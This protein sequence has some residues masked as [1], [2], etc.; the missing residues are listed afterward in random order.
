MLLVSFVLVTPQ[1]VTAAGKMVIKPILKAGWRYDSNYFKSET[2]DHAVSTYS[3]KPGILVGYETAKSIIS[4]D[5]SL[6]FQKYHDEDD[7]PAGL[8]GADEDDYTGQLAVFKAESQL[9]DRLSI[10]L[11]ETYM[12]T[13]DPASSE[14]YSN[15]TER[16]SGFTPHIQTTSLTT[17]IPGWKIPRRIVG[18]LICF[19]ISIEEPLLIWIIRF[20]PGIMIK[21]PRI[22]HPTSSW[23][24]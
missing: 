8:A 9:F 7:V 2:D 10:G 14:Q 13:R 18:N 6:D 15:A 20:G 23:P 11:D 3:V 24:T 12:K 1:W 4:L 16:N 5:A 22:T 17:M 21:A 19:T